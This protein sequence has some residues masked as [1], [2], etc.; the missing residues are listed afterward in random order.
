MRGKDRITVALDVDTREQAL[1]LASQLKDEVGVFKIGMQLF[2]S[3]GPAL[4][5]EIA[6]LGRPVF[7]DLKFHDI[8]NTVAAAGRV[9]TRL[10]ASIFNVHAAGGREMMRQVR[11]AVDEEADRLQQT[12]PLILAVTV[13]TS[14]DQQA[15]NSDLQVQLPVAELVVKWAQMA[16]EAGMD[17]VVA[18]PREITAIRT[19]CGEGFIILTPGVRPTWSETNDQ[20]R[21]MTPREAYQAGADY[22]VVGR[23]ITSAPDPVEA[24]RRI[25]E[26]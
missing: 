10:G 6:A 25:A 21:V 22:L 5:Q 14:I 2:N 1:A 12:R 18:S 17:G 9:I 19:A 4:V 11:Q 16:Q 26:E 7:V 24:A 8:P 3:A 20:K 23:P 13:L 15:V